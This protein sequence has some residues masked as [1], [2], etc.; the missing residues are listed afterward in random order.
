MSFP[1]LIESFHGFFSEVVCNTAR[2]EICLWFVS[3]RLDD[4]TAF[5]EYFM[6]SI[7]WKRSD[8]QNVF[9]GIIFCLKVAAHF[10]FFLQSS[11]DL[12]H[13]LKSHKEQ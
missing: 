10:L 8:I 13:V 12:L 9:L 6:G 4:M 11:A 5:W 1:V 2:W 7:A 3:S